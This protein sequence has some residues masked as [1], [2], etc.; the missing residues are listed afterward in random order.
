V[1]VPKVQPPRAVESDLLPI[2]L[3]ATLG[4]VLRP[5]YFSI[6]LT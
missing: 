1:P 3:T 6:K 5:V 4:K 2:S